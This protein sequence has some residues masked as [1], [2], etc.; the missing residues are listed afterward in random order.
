MR[1]ASIDLRAASGSSVACCFLDEYARGDDPLGSRET[2]PANTI[3]LAERESGDGDVDVVAGDF[4]SA[5]I[6]GPCE[7][8]AQVFAMAVSSSGGMPPDSDRR[9]HCSVGALCGE[10][11]DPPL[12]ALH[13]ARH[14]VWV[15]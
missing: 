4:P 2:V 11:V 3:L 14:E 12:E 13:L 7:P 6:A 1:V 9:R 15:A 10:G 5:M 8:T